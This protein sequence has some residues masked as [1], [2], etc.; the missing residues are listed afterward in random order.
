MSI[1]VDKGNVRLDYLIYGR[2]FDALIPT[3]ILLGLAK[4]YRVRRLGRQ[5]YPL[6]VLPLLAATL[7]LIALPSNYQGLPLA[8]LNVGGIAAWINPSA[9]EIPIAAATAAAMACFSVFL[10]APIRRPIFRIALVGVAFVALSITGEIRTM[11][12][13]DTP[14][15]QTLTLQ[16]LIL[17]L[18]PAEIAYDTN[19]ETLYGRNGYQF[20]LR[21]TKF[22]FFDSS[23]GKVPAT[24]LVLSRRDWPAA[25]ELGARQIAREDR[26]DEALWVLPG[27]LQNRLSQLGKLQ[28]R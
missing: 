7:W 11:S 14:W 10:L 13:L 17:P 9:E 26:L 16:E 21:G 28:P 22:L 5:A 1:L 23:T 3:L 6:A 8:A 2:Y 18:E 24:D 4:L 19:H 20:W 25:A 12:V 27:A 15:Q